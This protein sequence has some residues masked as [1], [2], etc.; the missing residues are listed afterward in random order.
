MSIISGSSVTG[1][2]A[3]AGGSEIERSLRFRSS[4]TAYLNRTPSTASNQ[5]TWTWSSWIKRGSLG[6]SQNLLSANTGNPPFA[7]FYITSSNQIGYDFDTTGTRYSGET[8]AVFRDPS[9]WY[10]VVMV[11]NTTNAT[12]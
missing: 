10:H 3:A 12:E 1:S 2:G 11:L 5:T 8:T 9:A 4:A 7:S 6:S